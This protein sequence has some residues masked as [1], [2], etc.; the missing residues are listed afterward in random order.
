MGGAETPAAGVPRG[1]EHWRLQLPKVGSEGGEEGQVEALSLGALN[2]RPGAE[3]ESGASTRRALTSSD[4]L[5]ANPLKG[6]GTGQHPLP[7]P[8][9]AEA[10]LDLGIIS[11]QEWLSGA[12]SPSPP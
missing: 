8:R 4:R 3:C 2:P 11:C 7:Q 12:C 9:G 10:C 5:P 1:S 6:Q